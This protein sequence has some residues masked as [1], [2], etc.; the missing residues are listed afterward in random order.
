M[1]IVDPLPAWVQ[2]ANL[3]YGE[4]VAQ[5][6]KLRNTLA[7]LLDAMLERNPEVRANPIYAAAMRAYRE[8]GNG[9]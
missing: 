3:T 8:T 2:Q 5:V 6:T 4:L 7:P 9:W 1:S